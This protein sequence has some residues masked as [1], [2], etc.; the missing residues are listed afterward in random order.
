MATITSEPSVTGD[1][2]RTPTRSL[3]KATLKSEGSKGG[4]DGGSVVAGGAAS[5]A[6]SEISKPKPM[7]VRKISQWSLVKKKL[8]IRGDAAG[9]TKGSMSTGN[10]ILIRTASKRSLSTVNTSINNQSNN[11][12]SQAESVRVENTYQLGPQ[13]EC[14]FRPLRVRRE[15]ESLVETI[16]ADERYDASRCGFITVRITEAVKDRVKTL[17]FSRHKLVVQTMLSSASGQSFEIASRCLW[18]A[19]TD[20][21]TTVVYQNPS[22]F[23]VVSV[24]GLYYE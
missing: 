10:P 22:L 5:E 9:P 23:A 19:E 8:N 16:L 2:P 13:S 21:Y 24:Y 6:N 17:G 18:N 1:L 3:E 14:T 20:N 12:N 7:P 11:G 4:S 15:V